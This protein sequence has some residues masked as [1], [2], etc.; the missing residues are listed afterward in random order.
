ML[1]GGASPSHALLLLAVEAVLAYVAELKR[2]RDVV[3]VG[4]DRQQL[5]SEAREALIDA[6]QCRKYVSVFTP[7]AAA[8]LRSNPVAALSHWVKFHEQ[9]RHVL[10]DVWRQESLAGN[11]S[12]R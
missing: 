11:P 8:E 4:V 3:L 5:P 6:E 2:S 1:D 7:Y 9:D 12:N 10:A